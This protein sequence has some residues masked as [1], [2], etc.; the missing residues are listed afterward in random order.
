MS[1]EDEI[2]GQESYCESEVV[3]DVSEAAGRSEVTET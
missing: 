1:D 2:R 3:F